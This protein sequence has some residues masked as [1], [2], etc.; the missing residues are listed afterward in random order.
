MT[1]TPVA[2]LALGLA[3]L[4]I[5]LLFYHD[6]LNGKVIMG[7]VMVPFTPCRNEPQVFDFGSSY[8]PLYPT[9]GTSY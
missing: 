7:N 4:A 6:H 5:V 8:R 1:H 2:Y 9:Y 3:S